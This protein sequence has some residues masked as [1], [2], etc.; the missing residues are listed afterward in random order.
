MFRVLFWIA[1]IVL[2]VGA[3]LLWGLFR[4]ALF[5]RRVERARKDFARHRAA[6][7]EQFLAAAGATGKPRGLRWK[8]A[9]LRDGL[10][11]A[12]DRANGELV[13]LV[14][15]TISFEAIEGG[16]M[17]EVEAVSNLRAATAIFSWIHGEWT[18]AGR[19][20]FNLEPPEV[21]ARYGDSLDHV[22][23]DF[24]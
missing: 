22:H 2:A 11:L 5:S 1:V 21:L 4:R 23:T 8:S 7:E 10:I 9:E 12:R 16:D 13:G 19:A 17:E 24:A 3:W 20:V 15:A 18:T 14:G 6:L